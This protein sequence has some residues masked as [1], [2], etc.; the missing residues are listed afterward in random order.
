MEGNTNNMNNMNLT[1]DFQNHPEPEKQKN[2]YLTM[3]IGAVI[4]A[5]CIV[6]AGGSGWAARVGV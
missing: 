6:V 2:P 5:L 4:M 3:K 1:P